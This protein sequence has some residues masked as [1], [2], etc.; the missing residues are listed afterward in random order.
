ML[1]KKPV[2]SVVFFTG[3]LLIFIFLSYFLLSFTSNFRLVLAIAETLTAVILLMTAFCAVTYFIIKRIY[4]PA[5]KQEGLISR[6]PQSAAKLPLKN[7]K[8]EVSAIPMTG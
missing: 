3:T 6:L 4:K 2:L 5:E 7:S 1:S 8:P